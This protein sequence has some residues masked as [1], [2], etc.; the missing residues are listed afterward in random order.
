[1]KKIFLF[2]LLFSVLWYLGFLYYKWKE[3]IDEELVKKQS[4]ITNFN[5][6]KEFLL[7]KST[8]PIPKWDLILLD[9]KWNI[10]HLEDRNIPLNKVKNLYAIQGTTCDIF[11]DNKN[12]QNINY[13]VRYSI[14]DFKTKKPIF[15]KCF[16]YSVTKDKKYFQIWTVQ[17]GKAFI[18]WNI[19]K[20]IIKAYDAPV[21]VK[22]NQSDFLPYA[23][24]KVSPIFQIT[25]LK[26]S[27][28]NLFVKSSDW[29][30]YNINLKNW[31]N[32]ILSW[33]L[34][35]TFFIKLT[36]KISNNTKIKFIDTNGTI[37]Y[38]KWDDMWNVNFQLKDYKIDTN[39]IDY[40]VE[41]WKF[42]VNV[43]K[44]SPDKKMSVSKKWTTLVIRWTKFSIDSW[45]DSFSTYLILWKIL[46][47]LHNKENIEL[48][49]KKAFSSILWD[50]LVSNVEKMKKLISFSVY[51]DILV[52][53]KYDFNFLNNPF[54]D[55]LSWNVLLLNIKYENGENIK[56]IVFKREKLQ[57]ILNKNLKKQNIS[58]CNWK[59]GC[60]KLLRYK[61]FV[62]NFCKSKRL[63]E[64]LDVDKLYYLLDAKNLNNFK[65]KQ[66]IQDK[67][68]ISNYVLLT[69]RNGWVN[70]SVN[71][72]TRIWFTYDWKIEDISIKRLEIK[73]TLN[74]IK[75]I[76]FACE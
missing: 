6:V 27:K 9:K 12:F 66:K 76:I 63:W 35:D 36:W 53:K 69:N 68:A 62:N 39:R 19:K 26:D 72:S 75:N 14:L 51:N 57:T 25:N 49:I 41:T 24:I 52:H 43:V 58:K 17:D 29:N 59:S 56:L 65:L 54:T 2:I 30:T 3:S 28:L 16:A 13:D 70:G 23:P 32:K 20:S 47:K 22:N 38:I 42:L 1:M 60:I 5:K 31:N 74:W 55:I 18:V 33:N 11:K 64:W 21:L 4:T 44:L 15:K 37:V 34:N 73:W 40:I 7:S 71:E 10:L 67:L 61:N 8:Y 48:D 46:Q 50:K 45:K